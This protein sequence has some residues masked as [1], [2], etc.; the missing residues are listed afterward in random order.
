MQDTAGPMLGACIKGTIPLTIISFAIGL[1]IALAGGAGAA[2]RRSGAGRD[3][4]FYISIIRGTP[5]LVQLFIVFFGLP[6]IGIKLPRF[7]AACHRPQPQ[8]RWL[9][10]RDHPRLDPLG[11][12]RTVRGG[13]HDRHGLPPEHAAHRAPAG[14]ADRRTPAVEHPALAGQGHLARVAS[15]WSPSSSARPRTPPHSAPSSSP[16]YALA[17]LYYWIICFLISL[18]Q[19]RLE[20]RLERYVA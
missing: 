17:A 20:H 5:L 8:R 19:D 4:A 6:E 13:D 12:A 18:G 10:R 15:C 16:L 11:A 3:R 1:V 2:L 7:I 14:R 9:C